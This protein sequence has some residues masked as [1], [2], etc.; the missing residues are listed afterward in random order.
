[1]SIL[2]APLVEYLHR[3]PA[4]NIKVCSQLKEESD[5]LAY[6]YPGVESFYM[7]VVNNQEHLAQLCE[8]SDCVVSLLPYALHGLVAKSCVAGKTHLVTASYVNDEVKALHESAK[9]AGITILNECGLDP[10]ID[11]FL[12][13]ECIQDVQAQGGVIESFVSY[14]GGLPAPESSDNALRYKF[15]WSPRGALVNT[16]SHA[17][18]LRNGQVV[19]ISGGGDLMSTHRDLN[20]LPG[21]ALEGFPNRDSTQYID[22]YGLGSQVHTVLRG[23]IFKTMFDEL[24]NI[25]IYLGTIRY[26]GF[27]E[28][29]KTMQLLG[30]IDTEV[31]PMLHN[32]GPD[33]TWRQLIINLLGLTD[34]EMFYEN[35]KQKLADRVGN[36]EG[37]ESLGLLEQTQVKKFGTPLDT[38]SHYLSKRLVYGKLFHKSLEAYFNVRLG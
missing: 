13:L 11:H 20:F 27:S 30:L 19:E 10:G 15:S 34:E 24:F 23:R 14:C 4:I 31:H 12:A 21:F 5:R 37:I 3:D 29:V 38:L 7:D 35:L 18:Y 22:L 28:C 25:F 2:Q 32:N 8:E 6:R 17:K 16:L 33:V 36:T 1:M 26:K 9:Q